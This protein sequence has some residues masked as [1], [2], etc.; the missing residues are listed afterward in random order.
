[1]PMK[2][3]FL[4][5]IAGVLLVDFAEAQI[6]MSGGVYHQNFDGLASVGSVNAWTDN[7]TLPGWYA[8]KSALPNAVTNY[9]ANAGSLTTGSLYSY[10]ATASADRA[11]GLLV[12][13]TP[14][15]MAF[16][17]RFTNDTGSAQSNLLVSF[18]GEQWRNANA[19]AQ[20]LAFSW[21]IGNALTNADAAGTLAWM[22]FDALNFS[23]LVNGG[24]VGALDGTAAANQII[25]TNVPLAGVV[26]QAGQ[27][28]FLR[29]FLARPGSGSSS[30]VAIDNLTVSF[31]AA[32]N[33]P[34]LIET[35]PQSEAA[36]EG[37]FALFSVV[38]SGSPLPDYQWQCNE[39]NLPG[40]TN[41]TLVLTN[42]AM[43]QAGNYSVLVTNF[44]G[45]TN[46]GTAALFV[47]PTSLLATN[48]GIKILT[49]NVAGNNS[50]TAT[51][52]A[53]WSTNSPQAQAIGRELAFLNPDIVAFNEIPVTNGVAQMPE[54][55]TAFLPGYFL[56]TN[57]TGDGHIQSVVASRFPITRSASHLAF[58]SLAPFGYTSSSFTRDLFEAQIAVPNWPLP[59]HVFVAHLKSTGSS[60]P[61]DDANKRAAMASAVSN[62]FATVYLPGTNGTDPFLLAGDLNEDAFF[63]DTDYVSGQPIQRLTGVATGL[64]MTIPVNPVTGADLTESIQDTLD[65][66]FD[67]ILP[68]AL[69]VSNIA[70]GEVFRTDLLTDFPPNLFSNDDIIASDHLPVLMVF[71]NPFNTPFKMLSI[72]RTNQS[73]TLQWESQN[74]RT[75]NIEASSNLVSWLPFATN[76]P[77][78]TTSSPFVFNSSNVADPV[79]FFRIYR[80][81]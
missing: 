40:A 29:W 26:V 77:V 51:N 15:N 48:G 76:L 78:A 21:R 33:S 66:R 16:G 58:S 67:Y 13:G 71:N 53:D 39:T 2:R 47:T 57:S 37:G 63:P 41:S 24:T 9:I 1:M 34:P 73:V 80:T 56:A 59:L 44:D 42:L 18:I 4:I 23:T 28:L 38:A 60:N 52:P 19:V 45:V 62:Y 81:P 10:G 72:A 35:P 68:C 25:F 14:G 49:Y 22:P 3:P 69:L 30:G 20:T 12:S 55:M 5:L 31:Q 74:N 36:G 65:T 11:L 50:G 7:S 27:E 61:Q 43:N 8:S 17:I 6:S 64:Q 46:S 79:K 75:Y 32:G 70:G 54:W